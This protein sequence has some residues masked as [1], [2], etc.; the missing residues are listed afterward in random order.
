MNNDASNKNQQKKKLDPVEV[1]YVDQGIVTI[2][3]EATHDQEKENLIVDN[4][5]LYFVS[6]ARS[7]SKAPTIG[8]SF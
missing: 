2:S 8:K 4:L 3:N 5:A 6:L 7:M 1:V